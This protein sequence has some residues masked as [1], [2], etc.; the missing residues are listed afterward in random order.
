MPQPGMPG[1]LPWGPAPHPH[2]RGPRRFPDSRADAEWWPRGPERRGIDAAGACAGAVHLLR[3]AH[4]GHPGR[5]R[6]VGRCS[7]PGSL[8]APACPDG[9]WSSPPGIAGVVF[10]ADRHRRHVPTHLPVATVRRVWVARLC[11]RWPGHRRPERCRHLPAAELARGCQDPP[12][13]PSGHRSEPAMRAGH[14]RGLRE[15]AGDCVPRPP[16]LS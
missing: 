13:E 9:C 14:R 11:H 3:R 12:G 4:A 2:W 15:H 7:H 10:S 6:V 8:A 5:L 16:G 1:R